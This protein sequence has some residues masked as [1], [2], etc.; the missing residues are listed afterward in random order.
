MRAGDASGR[1]VFAPTD[2]HKAVEGLSGTPM[3]TPG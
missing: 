1:E 3:L 2:G